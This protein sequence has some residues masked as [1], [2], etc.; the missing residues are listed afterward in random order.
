[1]IKVFSKLTKYI[2]PESRSSKKKDKYQRDRQIVKLL[3][4]KDKCKISSQ[5]EK[6][7]YKGTN[8]RATAEIRPFEKTME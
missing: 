8:I 4:I 1:M 6:I 5:Q 7:I 2:K 3:K